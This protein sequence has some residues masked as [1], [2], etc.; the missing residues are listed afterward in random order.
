MRTL[1]LAVLLLASC[2]A[3][4]RDEPVAVVEAFG[5]ALAAGDGAA[6][7]ALLAPDVLIYE[8]G[9]QEASLDE[10][11]TSHLQADMEFLAGATV[12]VLD[13]RAHA[14]G[15]LAVVTTRTRVTGAYKGKPYDQ[16]STETMALRRDG[17]TWRIA[18]IHWSSRA[19]K[20][21]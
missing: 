9:G 6:V 4:V 16:F 11:A 3:P 7:R 5:K 2:A 8:F 10:Y 13:R 12:E 21:P 18:H 15:D 19:A 20:K 14:D 1:A 17:A